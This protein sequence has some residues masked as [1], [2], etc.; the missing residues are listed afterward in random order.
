[1]AAADL[2]EREFAGAKL[3]AQ[4][5]SQG[6]RLEIYGGGRGRCHRLS[7]APDLRPASARNL[8]LPR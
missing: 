5:I 8:G 7:P 2:F 1:M 6:G 3:S 4:G